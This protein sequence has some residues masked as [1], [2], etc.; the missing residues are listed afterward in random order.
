MDGVGNINLSQE[1]VLEN[2][3][4]PVTSPKEMTLNPGTKV[5]YTD[6]SP[7]VGAKLTLDDY[8]KG[9]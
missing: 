6:H 7:M 5:V 3:S 2:D 1:F 9:Q 8:N 4:S